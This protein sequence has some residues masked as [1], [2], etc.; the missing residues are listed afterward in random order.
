MIEMLGAE[1]GPFRRAGE[2][3]EIKTRKK[4]LE[5]ADR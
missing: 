2:S 4:F 1:A 3:Y 5:A